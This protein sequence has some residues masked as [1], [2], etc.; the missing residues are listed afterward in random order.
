MLPSTLAIL[1]LNSTRFLQSQV[2]AHSSLVTVQLAVA[3]GPRPK[4]PDEKSLA[5]P[6]TQPAPL[7]SRTF[8]GRVILSSSGSALVTINDEKRIERQRLTI[9]SQTAVLWQ[10]ATKPGQPSLYKELPFVGRE[11]SGA[12]GGRDRLTFLLAKTSLLDPL[13]AYILA[14]DNPRPILE[15]EGVTT[16]T[17]RPDSTMQDGTPV[18]IVMATDDK[19]PNRG[20]PRRTYVFAYGKQDKLLRRFYSEIYQPDGTVKKR[21]ETFTNVQLN[22]NLDERLFTFVPPPGSQPFKPA[23]FPPAPKVS[24]L[25]ENAPEVPESLRFRTNPEGLKL[26]P[27]LGAAPTFTRGT[28][29]TGGAPSTTSASAAMRS[30]GRT[31]RTSDRSP[32]PAA[33]SPLLVLPEGGAAVGGTYSFGTVTVLGKRLIEETFVLKNNG[34]QPLTIERLANSCDCLSSKLA[35]GTL[36]LSLAPGKLAQVKVVMD[37]AKVTPGP[38]QKSVSVYL[39]GQ[40]AT[41]AAQLQLLGELTPWVSFVPSVALFGQVKAGEV[42]RP[43]SVVATLQPELAAKL[44]ASKLPFPPYFARQEGVLLLASADQK[45]LKEGQYR[46]DIRVDQSAFIGPLQ[47]TI[48]IINGVPV[49]GGSGAP[50]TEPT[51]S[52]FGWGSRVSLPVAA[53]VIGDLS[54]T[55]ALAAFGQVK[56]GDAPSRTRRVLV[57]GKE[58]LLAA[59]KVSVLN[60]AVLAKLLPAAEGKPGTRELEILLA[61]DAPEG[62]L[63]AKIILSHEA[64][65]VR[66]Q[67][68]VSAFYSEAMAILKPNELAMWKQ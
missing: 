64:T 3:R 40:Q 24:S 6:V 15:R 21:T 45:G 16:W 66:L 65:R 59:L 54:A 14:G 41:P 57:Q 12:S 49:L 34:S 8:T 33:N 2:R 37:L 58:E 28:G 55:P 4:V 60:G 43:V 53:Q 27:A 56:R 39:Q 29:S 22:P 67:L 46:F 61:P 63:Q 7:V 23:P 52:P 17:T 13:T 11:D 9:N 1:A 44:R 18:T 50:G 26:D 51:P 68:P 25:P 19:D 20:K 36:P 30:P 10:A 62:L 38:Q 31:L 32:A 47:A 5:T 48:G 42:S 35:E